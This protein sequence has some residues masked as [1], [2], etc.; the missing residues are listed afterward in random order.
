MLCS[1]AISLAY[2]IPAK[3]IPQTEAQYNHILFLLDFLQII[4]TVE[5]GPRIS[6]KHFP[7]PNLGLGRN[8]N[9]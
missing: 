3:T 8:E 9:M 6:V 2:K 4:A 1:S 5:T 7:S